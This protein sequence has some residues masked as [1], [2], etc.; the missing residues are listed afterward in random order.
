MRQGRRY[1]LSAEQK[2][3][4]WQRWKAGKSLHEIG[5]ADGPKPDD[6]FNESEDVAIT[7]AHSEAA[8]RRVAD[9]LPAGTALEDIGV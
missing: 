4:I 9:G 3:E 8:L 6:L 7:L 5:R 1:G 2:V